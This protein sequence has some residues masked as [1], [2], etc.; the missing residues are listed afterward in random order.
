M[1]DAL[2]LPPL[3]EV[4]RERLRDVVNGA[5][6]EWIE[7]DGRGGFAAGTALG[8]NTRR[9]H[10][11]VVVARKPPADR[12]VLLSRFAE[13]LVAADGTRT[14]LDVSFYPDAVFPAGH[15]YLEGFALD[16]WPV[17][18]YRVGDSE[19]VKEL[20]HSRRTRVLVIRWRLRGEPAVLELRPL[21]AGRPVDSLARADAAMRAEAEASERLVA[22]QPWDDVPP[23]ILSFGE[24]VWQQ[25]PVRYH[26]A[27]YPREA[28]AGRPD[29]EDLFAPGVLRMP[30][31]G[32]APASIAC[33]TVPARVSRADQWMREELRRREAVAS[34]GRRLAPGDAQLSTLAA[35]LALAGDAFVVER[36]AGATILAGYPWLLDRGRD[37][38]IALPGLCIELQRFDDAR[39]VLETLA[40]HMRDGLVPARFP[41]TGG[42]VPDDHY[43][44]P[45]ASLWFVRAVAA[46]HEAGGDARG[47]WPAAREVLR[48]YEAG[49]SFGI[50]LGA[51]GLLRHRV[52]DEEAGVRPGRGVEVNALWFDTLLAAAALPFATDAAHLRDR[53]DR[54][55]GAFGAFWFA[56]GGYAGDGLDT[57]GRLDTTL[58]A[59]QLMAAALPHA[60]L[61][62]ERIRGIVNAVERELLVP[63]G[64]RAIA[65]RHARGEP[66]PGRPGPPAVAETWRTGPFVAAYLRAHGSD[67]AARTHARS[68]LLRIEPLLARATLGHLPEAAAAASP[69]E[70]AGAP[71]SSAAAGA[72]LEAL[73]LV[74][75]TRER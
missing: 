29:R 24:G 26:R 22:Y 58:R 74:G 13:T 38:G 39:A 56:E 50:G 73:A 66:G 3:L 12:C 14:E 64:V 68:L 5:R 32:H 57:D 17:W 45:D 72:L 41:H 44:S 16:P 63:G 47:L 9:E 30:L 2:P 1:D 71:A 52:T 42:H 23:V 27:T 21:F 34:A 8:A 28:E 11:L 35:H 48:A 60:P 37:A 10:G 33:G 70:P 7:P 61:G 67:R 19:L 31:D 54:C 15:E 6:I 69:H 59:G 51:D 49:T 65:P 53:A 62:P 4:P 20:F 18:R 43:A 55:R 75:R 46:L 40:A 36:G 25:A